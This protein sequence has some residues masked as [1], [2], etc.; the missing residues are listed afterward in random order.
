MD[1]PFWKM[2][3]AG[4]DFVLFDDRAGT[5]PAHDRRWLAALGGRQTGIGCEGFILIQR[6]AAADVR[7]RFFNPDGG[8]AELCGNGARCLAR[9]AYEL[10]AAPARMTIETQAGRLRAEVA[11]PDVQ[12]QMPPPTQWRMNLSLALGDRT[13]VC[14]AVNTGVPHAVVEAA[15]LDAFPVETLGRA[16]RHHAAFA[17]AGTNADFM[18]ITAPDALRIRTYERGVEAET[19][20]C[21]TGAVAAA[22]VAARL[23]RVQPPV[24]VTTAGGY[25]LTIAFELTADG[26]AAVTLRGPAEHVFRGTVTRA[27]GA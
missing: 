17:P 23:G 19:G 20:A 3:G 21:G 25:R 18:A 9:L 16:I 15:D 8:E 7:M 14:H 6:A 27:E 5:F 12:V 10:G 13:L 11:G 1:F 26:A 2:H 24:A 4:N 22:L